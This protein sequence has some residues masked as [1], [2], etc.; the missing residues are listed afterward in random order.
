MS[1]KE[2]QDTYE[3]CLES[4]VDCVAS[5][6]QR[7]RFGAGIEEFVSALQQR[8]KE[9]EEET[10]LHIGTNFELCD[11]VKQLEAFKAKVMGSKVFVALHKFGIVQSASFLSE[12]SEDCP[13]DLLALSCECTGEQI[14]KEGFE[15]IRVFAVPVSDIEPEVQAHGECLDC[16]GSGGVE[17][18]GNAEDGPIVVP[19]GCRSEIS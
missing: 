8:V 1:T 7:K 10:E 16:Q 17:V 4:L 2:L 13:Y 6:E 9:L 15:K 18:Y 5:L 12:G 19:C 14:R 3:Q 11:K